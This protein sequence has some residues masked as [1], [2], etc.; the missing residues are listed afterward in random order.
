[1]KAKKSLMTIA[2]ALLLVAVTIGGTVAYMKDQ[3]NTVKNT[4]TVGNV[5][6]KLDEADIE[7]AEDG[8]VKA[9]NSRNEA[10]NDYKTVYPGF[11]Y[12]KDPTVTVLHPSEKCWVFVKVEVNKEAALQLFNNLTGENQKDF[13]AAIKAAE[14]LGTEYDKDTWV[15]LEGTLKLN[16]KMVEAVL[17][18][19]EPVEKTTKDVVLPAVMKQM[20]IPEEWGY[21][22]IKGFENGK[23]NFTAYAIQWQGLATMK[24]AA[25][26]LHLLGE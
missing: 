18:Y 14:A 26:A 12:P 22:Q 25:K 17:A 9:K 6:I 5:D 3:T 24:D 16:G 8:T 11:T 21:D 19:K 23:L 2:M 13:N 1:M 7:F 10:G 15:P 4:F 20:V